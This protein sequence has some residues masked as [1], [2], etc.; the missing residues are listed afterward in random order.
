MSYW[1]IGTI[2]TIKL[3]LKLGFIIHPEKSSLQP[4]QEMNYL[5]LFSIQR[6]CRLHIPVKKGENVLS[7]AKGFL[8]KIVLQ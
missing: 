4:R 5:D 8:K 6:K 3:F 1:L 2:K 7:L